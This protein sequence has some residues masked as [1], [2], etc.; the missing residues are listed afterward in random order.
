MTVPWRWEWRH[1]QAARGYL[2]RL[3]EA[4]VLA[5]LVVAAVLT[6][7]DEVDR[8]GTLGLDRDLAPFHLVHPACRAEAYHLRVRCSSMIACALTAAS[9][10]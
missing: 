6:V 3:E 1:R 9:R 2:V 10:C 7:R 4:D 5:Q 8:V